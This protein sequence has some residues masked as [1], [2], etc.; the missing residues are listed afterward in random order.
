MLYTVSPEILGLIYP[1]IQNHPPQHSHVDFLCYPSY[2]LHYRNVPICT[3]MDPASAVIGIVS[4]GF[5]VLGKVN[6]VRKAIKDAPESIRS[7]QESC[8]VVELLLE[9]LKST[10][11]H[12]IPRSSA[13]DAYL[14]L[15]RDNA[16]KC[17]QE[18]EA[19]V[20]R[21]VVRS[22]DGDDPSQP[23]IRL[24]KF[25]LSRSNFLE[26]SRKVKQLQE[27]LDRI[28]NFTQS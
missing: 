21:V 15:L 16:Q 28:L 9:K 8:T 5:T 18:V 7:L 4:F 12:K 1:L 11:T 19:A 14:C 10:E 24:K 23:E 2:T 6:E 26:F 3:L 25:M 13:E 27:A 17:L 22:A 20:E